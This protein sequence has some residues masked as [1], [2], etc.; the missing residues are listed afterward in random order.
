[1]IISKNT[2]SGLLL[3]LFALIACEPAQN[4][5]TGRPAAPAQNVE[6]LVVTPQTVSQQQTLT[7]TL[8]ASTI[9]RLYNEVSGIIT[10]LPFYEGD[11]V[12]KGIPIIKLDDGLIKA[13]MEKSVAQKKQAALDLQ[14]L[15][16]LIP[17]KLASEEDLTRARTELEIATAEE[18]LQ[19]T[20]LSKTEIHAPFDGIITERHYEP[21]DVAPQHSHILT[22][23]DPASLHIK[24]QIS[25]NW[26][27]MVDLESEIEISI[28]ALG[29]SA[30]KGKVTRIH[31]SIDPKTRKG[32]VEVDFI[33]LPMNAKSGQLAR[34]QM[35]STP[36]ERLLLPSYVVRH[37]A[38]GAYVFTV[39]DESKAV[40]TYIAKGLEFAD[41]MEITEGLTL[42]QKVITKGF[43]ALR[44]GSSIK[45][46]IPGNNT[47]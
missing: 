40:K 18:K 44:D 5:S 22:L 41:Q 32:I 15:K 7:G 11:T 25:E 27:A 1:M 3:V 4:S 16:K 38:M 12:S 46:V 37:D 19:R 29:K 14:R 42:N 39:N 24:M 28:D 20:R 30:H 17:K 45:I 6:I 21:G 2:F 31:P 47:P 34:I 23:I 13:E 26:L 35:R 8:E 43:T 36:S 10:D 33:S 9:V